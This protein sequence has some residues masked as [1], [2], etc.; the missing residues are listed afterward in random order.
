MAGRSIVDGANRR[1]NFARHFIEMVI[2]MLAGMVV[3]GAVVSGVF[4]LFGHG[5]LLHYVGVRALLMT[6]YMTVG[7]ALW[8]RH[9]RHCWPA[10]IEM[11]AAMFVPFII[12]IGLY[13]AGVLPGPRF[14]ALMHVLML[15]AMVVAMIRRRDEYSRD[16]RAHPRGSLHPA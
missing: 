12:L 8:M 13:E 7:M 10:V 4:A 15:P 14:L 9:R 5:N 2:A 1:R 11:A 6:L 3:L 16:H